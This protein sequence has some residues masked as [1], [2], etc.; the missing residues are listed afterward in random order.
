MKTAA[1]RLAQRNA[2]SVVIYGR[3]KSTLL[4]SNNSPYSRNGHTYRSLNKLCKVS[5]PCISR[6]FL[7]QVRFVHNV[8]PRP[9]KTVNT[10]GQ[11]IIF[12]SQRQIGTLGR[13]VSRFLKIRYFFLAGAVGGGVALNEV[14]MV[15]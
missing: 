9:L 13:V 8:I 1:R 12:V 3:S 11:P 6:I 4:H 15:R 7:P 10:N 14:S 2:K 5:S